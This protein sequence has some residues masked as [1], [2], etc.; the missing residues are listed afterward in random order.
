MNNS[1]SIE[2]ALQQIE[3]GKFSF[4]MVDTIKKTHPALVDD[5]IPSKVPL[6]TLH[7]VLQRLLR[8]RVPDLLLLDW[9][10]PGVSGIELCRRLRVREDTRHLPIILLT[11]RGEE[12][13][14]DASNGCCDCN[15]RTSGWSSRMRYHVL[16]LGW[17]TIRCT[18]STRSNS[19]R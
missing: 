14:K 12:S 8:E 19:S 7:R 10:L 3:A 11:A 18:P 15:G 16:R 4:G 9:M 13:E 5:L 2:Q 1:M 6:A 17:R